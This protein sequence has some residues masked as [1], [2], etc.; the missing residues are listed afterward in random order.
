MRLFNFISNKIRVVTAVAIAAGICATS[1]MSSMAGIWTEE[2]A[3][4]ARDFMDHYNAL[5]EYIKENSVNLR[6]DW[7]RAVADTPVVSVY[8]GTPENDIEGQF[9]MGGAIRAFEFA[10][11]YRFPTALRGEP[12]PL[13]ACVWDDVLA[14][15]AKKAL[16]DEITIGG[17]VTGFVFDN[18]GLLDQSLVYD[19]GSY[20]ELTTDYPYSISALSTYT[21][22]TVDE[23]VMACF[24][25]EDYFGPFVQRDAARRV[26]A[27]VLNYNGEKYLKF[28]TC[29]EDDYAHERKIEDML[30]LE[31][32]DAFY[33]F[34]GR[35]AEKDNSES[36]VSGTISIE[37]DSIVIF[38]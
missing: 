14:E 13:K 2:E 20:F 7:P 18:T 25:D 29:Y 33:K 24:H 9:D 6:A 1:P 3:A 26:G 34:Y 17:G 28:V 8:K 12:Q 38:G 4:E 30:G 19:A 23:A 15:Y 16:L 32:S 35:S 10:Q 22:K 37:G 11:L 5:N 27:A 36:S 21:G 31:R